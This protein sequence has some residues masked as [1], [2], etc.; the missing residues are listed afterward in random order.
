MFSTIYCVSLTIRYL[1]ISYNVKILSIFKFCKKSKDFWRKIVFWKTGLIFTFSWS[2]RKRL[3]NVW[4]L[5]ISEPSLFTYYHNKIGSQSGIVSF[6]FVFMFALLG[7]LSPLK[8]SLFFFAL[9]SFF[10][11]IMSPPWMRKENKNTYRTGW[12]SLKSRF[13]NLT[14]AF[15]DNFL[16]FIIKLSFLERAF[17][18]LVFLSSALLNS[19]I[20]LVCNSSV[21]GPQ[22]GW[23]GRRETHAEHTR[24]VSKVGLSTWQGPFPT[25][26]Q[27]LFYRKNLINLGT[28]LLRHLISLDTALARHL[29]NLSS[30][31]VRCRSKLDN[32]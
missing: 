18:N 8:Y 20:A 31:V 17:L 26:F 27:L 15:S 12:K 23:E 30:A 2:P 11:K 16:G 6:F 14:G 29:I 4:P 13:F 9:L 10:L 24:K 19:L 21:A 22:P 1:C 7:V 3:R 32:T 25:F 5:I 28:A